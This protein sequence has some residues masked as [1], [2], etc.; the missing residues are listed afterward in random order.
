L[1]KSREAED[2]LLNLPVLQSPTTDDPKKSE[3]T[4]ASEDF[5][6]TDGEKLACGA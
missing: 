1:E 5:S 6:G 4:A 3:E 2:L